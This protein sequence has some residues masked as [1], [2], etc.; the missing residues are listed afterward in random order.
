MTSQTTT[1]NIWMLKNI[2][3]TKGPRTAN[4]VRNDFT[5]SFTCRFEYIK[6]AQ[7]NIFLVILLSDIEQSERAFNA[8]IPKLSY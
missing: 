5:W 2:T 1:K 4:V 6:L 3:S 7:Q 8:V